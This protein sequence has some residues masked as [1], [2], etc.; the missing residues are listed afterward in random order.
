MNEP[1]RLRTSRWPLHALLA[2]VLLMVGCGS[3]EV[4]ENVFDEISRMPTKE[5]MVEIDLGR[6]VVPVP[7][8]LESATERF[9]PANLMEIEMRLVAVADPG[10]AESVQRMKE[11]N[12]GRIRDRVIRV[13]RSTTRDDLTESEKAT[14][15]AHLLDAVQPLLGGEAVRQLVILPGRVD[16]L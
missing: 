16:E 1:L 13:C 4:Q 3:E 9:E 5:E 12:S 7:M 6:Y 15:K 11:R 14:L 8:I 10:E 2:G